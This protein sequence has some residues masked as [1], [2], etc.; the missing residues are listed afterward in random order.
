MK[1]KAS[2]KEIVYTNVH[3]DSVTVDIHRL[4]RNRAICGHYY[5]K[6]SGTSKPYTP[7]YDEHVKLLTY[8]MDTLG[9]SYIR[10]DHRN[11]DGYAVVRN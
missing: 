7:T 3:S 6:E 1:Y 8:I 10:K 5:C 2:T 9:S 4:S 11:L